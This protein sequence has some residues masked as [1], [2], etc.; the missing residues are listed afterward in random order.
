MVIGIFG[1]SCVGKSTLAELLKGKIDVEVYS[2]NDYL[3]LSK[4]ES[5]AKKLF[6]KKLQDAMTDGHIIYVISEK[7]HLSLLPNGSL[8]VLVTADLD[9][10]QERFATRMHGNIPESVKM[11]LQRKHGIFN[12]E[13]YDF[14]YHSNKDSFDFACDEIIDAIK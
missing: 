2:G 13:R 5:I 12:E 8:R 9:L 4:N 14:H 6:A 11:M 10:I 3:R 1:E 7:E